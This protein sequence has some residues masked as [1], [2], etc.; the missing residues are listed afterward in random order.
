MSNK[1]ISDD[2]GI[3]P[4]GR[5]GSPGGPGRFGSPGGHGFSN[6]SVIDPG[7]LIRGPVFDHYN[8]IDPGNF[9]T[10]RGN[11]PRPPYRPPSS[12]RAPIPGGRKRK[13]TK[14]KK[15]KLRKR[16]TKK[17][18]LRKRK[19]KKRKLRKRKTKKRN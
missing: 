7:Y 1:F 4:R 18:K 10:F 3:P 19:T 16:K 2:F 12:N 6:M 15:R 8:V 13:A 14:K 9:G 17:R 11:F 5:F